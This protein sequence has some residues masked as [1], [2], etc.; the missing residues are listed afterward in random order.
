MIISFSCPLI[1]CLNTFTFLIFHLAFFFVDIPYPGHIERRYLEV[2]VGATWVEATML[3][4]GFD[5]P[6]RFFID[7][8]Q[9]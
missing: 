5:T 4:S 8:V 6:R 3:T 1:S 7:T 2:P 9:V